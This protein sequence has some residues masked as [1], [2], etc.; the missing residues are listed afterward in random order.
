MKAD[1]QLLWAL[2]I[3]SLALSVDAFG[4]DLTVGLSIGPPHCR[5]PAAKRPKLQ[6]ERGL[7]SKEA[8]RAGWYSPVVADFNG[9]GW[10]DFAWAIPF[11]VNSK[12]EAYVLDE[13]LL[14]GAAKAWRP[15]FKGKRS[16]MFEADTDLWPWFRVDLT[17]VSFVYSKASRA[18]FVLGLRDGMEWGTTQIGWGCR[19][20]SSVHRWDHSADAFKKVDDSTRDTVLNFY[21]THI[22]QRCERTPKP[23]N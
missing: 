20:F 16:S 23:R 9:D 17:D 21:Y 8:I 14:L 15:P 6:A 19:E 18:P 12:M 2:A 13:I 7:E 1:M 22:G 4:Q 11:P 5:P 10:C 3:G